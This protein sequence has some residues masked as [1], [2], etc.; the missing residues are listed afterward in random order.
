MDL[1]SSLH[2][3]FGFRAF[4]PGQEEAVRAALEGRDALVVMPTGSGKSLCYQ[5]PALMRDD[6]TVVV[7]PLVALMQDQVDG[8]RARGAGDKVALVNAQQS[9]EDNRA[10]IARAADGELRLLYVAPER[11]G[12]PGFLDRM[13]GVE[14]GL[15]VVD[16]AHCV[17]QW[18][19]DFRPDYFRL[20]AVAKRL[21]ARAVMASTATATARVAADIARR[22]ALRDPVKV[23]TGFD[24]PN[25]TFSVARPNGADK[26]AMLIDTLS[27]ED[28][29]P[30]IVYAGTR[31]GCEDLA[32]VIGSQLGV[33]AEPYH[34]GLDRERRAAVQ[35]RFLADETP[36]I[37][38]TNAFGMGVDKPNVRTVIHASTPPSLEAY[39]Q[40]AGRAGRDGLPGKAVLLAEPRDK[41]LHVHFIRQEQ[42]DDRLPRDVAGRLSWAAD[43]DGVF[44]EDA[45]E[46]ARA[47]GC[48]G[49]RLRSVLGHL[50]RAGVVEPS[51]APS[52]RVAGRLA[53]QYDHAA[54][55]RC[56]TSMEEGIRVR[57]RQYREIWAYAEADSCRRT[58][59]L[60]HFGDPSVPQVD[61]CCDVCVPAVKPVA[62]P[63]PPEVLASLDDA[64]FSVVR[65][66]RPNVGRTACVEILHGAQSKKVKE[67]SYD[68]LGAYAMASHMRRADILARVDQLLES[69]RLASTGG[70]FPKLKVVAQPAAAAA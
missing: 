51:P 56:R 50:T 14:I 63:P 36:V 8:L 23:T 41:A 10:A 1:A 25:L 2:Q 29:L 65:N 66:A 43:G 12:A 59:I 33:R 24:R 68:G 30:A 57:W 4:R 54:A 44:N 16:E 20:E 52:N 62:P 26:R 15:F 58:A 31:A 34:A 70:K 47:A 22:L 21:N 3:H 60:R 7:S 35:R 53:G 32:E 37:V 55:A 5:L 39:Y 27:R 45:L 28:A 19:H 18:G 38:A 69:G 11:F 49:E 48:D 64:I 6:L 67:N 46:L 13:A 9:G 61:N 17:S 42:L 40:E